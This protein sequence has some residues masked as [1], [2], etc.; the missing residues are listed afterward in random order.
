VADERHGIRERRGDR[1]G[2]STGSFRASETYNGDGKADINLAEHSTTERHDWLMNGGVT[3]STQ[4]GLDCT[5][6]KMLNRRL[7]GLLRI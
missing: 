6:W 5:E 4:P 3:L 1:R 2:Q 7:H